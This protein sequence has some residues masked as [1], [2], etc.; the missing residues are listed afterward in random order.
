[1]ATKSLKTAPPGAQSAPN[2]ESRMDAAAGMAARP[3]KVVDKPALLVVEQVSRQSGTKRYFA[4][5]PAYNVLAQEERLDR[6]T[7]RVQKLLTRYTWD[8]TLAKVDGNWTPPRPLTLPESHGSKSGL[9]SIA[10]SAAAARA[11]GPLDTLRSV[12]LTEMSTDEWIALADHPRC[13]SYAFAGRTSGRVASQ[14]GIDNPLRYVTAARLGDKV[15]KVDGHRRAVAWA[16][17]SLP[18]PGTVIATVIALTT[19]RQLLHLR[20]RHVSPRWPKASVRTH[21]SVLLLP[22][23]GLFATL[24]A[25][26]VLTEA[27][28]L[29]VRGASR[30]PA[31]SPAIDYGSVCKAFASELQQLAQLPPSTAL[32]QPGVLAAA[33]LSVPAVPDDLLF[34]EA[35]AHGAGAKQ[36]GKPDA[37]E[38]LLMAAARTPH[39]LLPK[40]RHL[41]QVRICRQALQALALW[42][43]QK[44]S[45]K[46]HW[47]DG[48]LQPGPSL[49]TYVEALRRLRS[50]D[51]EP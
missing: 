3:A 4:Y 47:L 38:A 32:L 35:V 29:V 5:D 22:D 42:R 27:L 1:M 2:S 25:R 30:L 15:Y 41:R 49:R 33:L 46:V 6:I 16:K 28:R 9:N 13:S 17:G 36:A 40:S 24:D 26:I 51:G 12:D 48:S 14:H 37:V 23:S 20:S 31:G 19:Y 43:K 45:G 8:F 18:R 39:A 21:R 11:A 7:R 44:S 34:F 50:L 10:A